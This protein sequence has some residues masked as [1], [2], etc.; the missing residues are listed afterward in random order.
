WMADAAD[1]RHR[2]ITV[3]APGTPP[4]TSNPIGLADAVGRHILFRAGDS[5]QWHEAFSADGLAWEHRVVTRNAATYEPAIYS[6]GVVLHVIYRGIDGQVYE[7]T[8]AATRSLGRNPPCAG[9]VTSY[10]VN[11]GRHH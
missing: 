7:E 1:W 2:N 8:P 10:V 5:G 4:A 6:D 3:A 9:N 11:G